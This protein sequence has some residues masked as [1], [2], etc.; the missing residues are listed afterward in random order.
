MTNQKTNT[1]I[2]F[3]GTPSSFF[4]MYVIC[5]VLS[6]IPFVG[7][8]LAFNYQTNWLIKNL[9]IEG[10]TLIYKAELGEKFM[11]MFVGIL[12]T[13][14]TVGIY[15][16]WFVPKVYHFIVEHTAFVDQ[17]APQSVVDPQTILI[18]TSITPPPS[19]PSSP[20]ALIQ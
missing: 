18:D 15:T 10:R 8:A 3:S 14:L 6:L 9:Q 11:L 19:Q 7:I 12:L 2:T 4:V 17:I 5:L 13:V 20:P 1:A 16:F